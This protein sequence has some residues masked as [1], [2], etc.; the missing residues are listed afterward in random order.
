MK[1]IAIFSNSSKEQAKD[2]AEYASIKIRD[3]GGKVIAEDEFCNCLESSFSFIEP[4]DKL[5]LKKKADIVL[6]FGGDGTI[7]S[8]AKLFLKTGV[9]IMGINVGKLGFLAEYHSDKLDKGL[10]D[11]MNGNFRVVERIVLEAEFKNKTYYALNDFV[12]E[13]SVTSRMITVKAFTNGNHVADYK[14][15]GLITT[16]PTGSTA[17]SLSCGGPIIAPG[18]PVFCLTPISPHTLN[19]RPLVVPDSS[20]I[21]LE[22]NSFSNSAQF[23][24]DGREILAIEN[25][26]S[27]IMR[28]SREKVK[29]IKPLTTSYYDLLREKLLWA[30]D[31]KTSQ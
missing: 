25:D 31:A 23:V 30:T 26:E 15:D 1:T 6:T 11:L 3:L 18:T 14:A 19:L 7:L 17:Y 29:L 28:K 16:T 24:V 2:F 27:V 9:P 12:L 13:K 4:C 8:A 20:E 22:L 5:D 10:T 21:K